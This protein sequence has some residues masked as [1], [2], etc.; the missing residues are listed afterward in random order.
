MLIRLGAEEQTFLRNEKRNKAAAIDFYAEHVFLFREQNNTW[1]TERAKENVVR[2]YPV[3][4]ILD[5]M[6]ESLNAL[7]AEL[8]YF[9][10]GAKRVY[11]HL[12][13]YSNIFAAHVM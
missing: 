6:E 12:R 11:D 3:V 7:A 5:Y 4:G 10:K 1:A 2:W 9:F 8:P 13:E